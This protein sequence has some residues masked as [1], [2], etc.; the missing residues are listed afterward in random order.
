MWVMRTGAAQL[1]SAPRTIATEYLL[2]RRLKMPTTIVFP[3]AVNM[4]QRF[5]PSRLD[6][7]HDRL[8]F[9][10]LMLWALIMLSIGAAA[11]FG[12]QSSGYSAFE[13]LALP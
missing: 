5:D 2:Q 13:L 8:C 9:G 3:L 6:P 7:L 1:G 11:H 10:I 12:T 4:A